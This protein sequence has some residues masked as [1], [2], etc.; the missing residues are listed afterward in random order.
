MK[1]SHILIIDDNQDILAMLKSM[2]EL[3]GYRVSV[4]DNIRD[5]EPAIKALMPN[6]I[7]MDML[8]SGAD[9]RE[10]CKQLKA[11]PLLSRIPVIMISAH[12]N[13]ETECLEAGAD[14]F[15]DKPFDMENLFDVVGAAVKQSAGSV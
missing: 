14:F 12:P 3:K 13:A 8:L 6:V 7:L 10:V 4:K 2:L 11:S 1:A 9:G 5:I 15:L